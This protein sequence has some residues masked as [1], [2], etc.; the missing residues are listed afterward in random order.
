[1]RGQGVFQR[2]WPK[3][4]RR[5]CA[6]RIFLSRRRQE[7][8]KEL[9]HWAVIH[10][11]PAM[12]KGTSKRALAS[13]VQQ[14]YACQIETA[15]KILQ[16]RA[17][18]KAADA[19]VC[20]GKL[21][22]K[23]LSGDNFQEEEHHIHRAYS[24]KKRTARYA[25]RPFF[26]PLVKGDILRDETSRKLYVVIAILHKDPYSVTLSVSPKEGSADNASESSFQVD[27]PSQQWIIISYDSSIDT[28]MPPITH[29]E[30]E[31]PSPRLLPHLDRQIENDHIFV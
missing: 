1:M 20:I 28:L 12:A 2:P 8:P 30:Q 25:K 15:Q 18:A 11:M 23:L 6:L 26:P 31:A 17:T 21:K 24:Y 14:G 4:K 22:T 10:T 5:L 27:L 3:D 19:R 7:N 29:F 9:K 16:A 13:L